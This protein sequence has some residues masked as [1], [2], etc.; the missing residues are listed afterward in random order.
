MILNREDSIYAATKLMK[1]F[2]DF[3]RIDDYFRA[4]KIER[5]KDIPS[6]L[7]GMSMEDDL[8]QKFDMHPQ[9]MDFKV[10]QIPTKLFD[11]LLE[12]TASFSPDENPGKTLKLVVKETNTNTIVGFIR[13][14]SPLINS[15]P[16]NDFLGDVP[17]LDIFNKRAIMGFNIVPV[18]PFGY[19]CL[20]GKLL[21]SI[22]CSHASRRMLNQK[23]DT[24]FCLF[25]TTSLYGN[26]KGA[27]MYDGMRPYLR[28][29][30][31]TESK[32]LLT[33]GEEIYPEM[34]DW[35]TERNGGEELIHKG[36]SSR[37]LK[38]QTKMVGVIKT[39]LKEH[40]SKAYELFSK[41]IAK[42]SDVTTQKRFYMSTYGYENV[43][44]VLLGK[45]NVLTKSQ[46]YDKFELENIVTWWKKLATKRYNNVVA[47]GRIR[48]E[49]EVWNKDTMDRID[50]I[51]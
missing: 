28:Y 23:Y 10:V 46:S 2:R 22:C 36:A 17:D 37:K 5:V 35:F 34:R 29:K 38:M 39:S 15:K 45:T 51:R 3:N 21:A 26:I 27:S 12:K 9:D 42:A 7:P 1:Y 8:F 25:E 16:R 33:L 32:F 18:Q 43:R 47:D 30:G 14:G 48:K 41:E 44:D 4:R 49:L 11:T 31:D 24:E 13:Y 50:I 20:G 19:N 6:P 40:D